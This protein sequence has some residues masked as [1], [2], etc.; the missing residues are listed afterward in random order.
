MLLIVDLFRLHL[1]HR[2]EF[3]WR[4]TDPDG[5]I[6]NNFTFEA[7]FR[8]PVPLFLKKRAKSGVLPINSIYGDR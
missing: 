7:V 5:L 1:Q 3:P 4:L 2:I 6:S 8:T